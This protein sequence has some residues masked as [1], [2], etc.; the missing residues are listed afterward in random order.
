MDPWAF[1]W[2]QLLT[3]IG[4]VITGAIAIGGFGTFERWRKQKLEEK[5]ID[6][7]LEALAIA[8]QSKFVFE[9]IR[10]P[11]AYG[12]EWTDMPQ[13]PGDTEDKRS[14]RGAYYAPLKR[15]NQNKEFFEGI[16]KIQP[17][18]MALFGPHVENVFLKV[19]QVRRDIEIAAQM[20]ME[21]VD[22]RYRGD[23]ASTI[24][25]YKQFRVD[26][27]GHGGQYTKEGDRVGTK[28]KEFQTGMEAIFRPVV[29]RE[30][31]EVKEPT[32]ENVRS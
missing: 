15:I 13:R 10:G 18:V 12:Y 23:D 31:R 27:Y 21:N 14:S 11:M 20:L 5:K 8:Y 17:L 9:H 7:A 16:W 29:D 3:I 32:T 25:L 19:H 24:E 26:I 28:L 1:G 6:A 22:D 4:F 30:Y 2:T